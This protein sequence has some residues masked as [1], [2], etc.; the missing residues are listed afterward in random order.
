MTEWTNYETER[1]YTDFFEGAWTGETPETLRDYVL[2]TVIAQTKR[3]F[4]RDYALAF[5][6]EVDWLQINL[7]LNER[8]SA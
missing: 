1:V 7:Y 5:V 3:G 2:D 4:G 6:G 8:K